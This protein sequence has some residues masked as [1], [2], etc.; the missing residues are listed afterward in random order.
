MVDE[1]KL[2]EAYNEGIESV[3]GSVNEMH[4][5][6]TEQNLALAQN[7]LELKE[8]MLDLRKDNKILSARIAELEAR[9]NKDSNNSSKPP[10]SDGY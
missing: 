9:L 10:S 4:N 5:R 8:E 7:I 2:I 1:N 3:L 6:F